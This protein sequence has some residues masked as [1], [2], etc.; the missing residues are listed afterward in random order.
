MTSDKQPYGLEATLRLS[1]GEQWAS[2]VLRLL[3]ALLVTGQRMRGTGGTALRL[4]RTW[5]SKT[6]GSLEYGA[7][8]ALEA[9]PKA[10]GCSL[11]QHLGEY[12]RELGERAACSL[13]FSRWICYQNHSSLSGTDMPV[14]IESI[15]TAI[16]GPISKVRNGDLLS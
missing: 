8:G 3:L 10:Y 7:R 14:S 12:S 1:A 6:K 13:V 9:M 4:V 16:P 11:G 2:W 5:Q 15:S